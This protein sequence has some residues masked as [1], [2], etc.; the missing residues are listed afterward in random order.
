MS[1]STPQPPPP[2]EE[3]YL[4]SEDSDFAPDVHQTTALS[5]PSSSDTEDDRDPTI[6]KPSKRK[7]PQEAQDLGFENSGDEAIIG[8]ANKKRRKKGKG[9]D[10]E[11]QDEEDD[12][13]G[14]G[15][16]VKTRAMRAAAL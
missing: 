1:L 6:K 13:G 16:F 10:V 3:E 4:S 14:E 8:K 9:K 12:E 11:R 15:G 7:Q 2:D 5:S